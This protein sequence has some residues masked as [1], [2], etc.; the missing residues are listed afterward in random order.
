MNLAYSVTGFLLACAVAA[1]HSTF[2]RHY[3]LERLY[4]DEASGTEKRRIMKVVWH[5]PS[6]LWIVAAALV[7]TG[8]LTSQPS[9]LLSLL[10]IFIFAAAG[11]GNLW[12][13]RRPFIGGLLLL[14][15]AGLIGADAVI[16]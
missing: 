6:L 5:L 14:S 8:R 10:A 3:R 13:H 15:I 12:A 16:A 7:L 1:L 2:A 4:Q 9:A 11:I